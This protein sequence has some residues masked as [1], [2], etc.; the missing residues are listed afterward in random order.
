MPVCAAVKRALYAFTPGLG[1]VAAKQAHVNEGKETTASSAVVG[2]CNGLLVRNDKLLQGLQRT[3][4]ED[5]KAHLVSNGLDASTAAETAL[6]ANERVT[7]ARYAAWAKESPA[8]HDELREAGGYDL[9]TTCD[10]LATI[11]A[12][13]KDIGEFE[14]ATFCI[15]GTAP[16]S[17]SLF[18]P[19]AFKR[20]RIA[21]ATSKR[22]VVLDQAD[23]LGLC[24]ALGRLDGPNDT[25]ENAFY[26]HIV[27]FIA[28]PSSFLSSNDDVVDL[29]ASAFHF[30]LCPADPSLT[31]ARSRLLRLVQWRFHSFSNVQ[32]RRQRKKDACEHCRF[33]REPLE[34][35]SFRSGKPFHCR[36][37]QVVL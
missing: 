30:A 7:S 3:E 15:E 14:G 26:T 8:L 18:Q 23:P 5:L 13:L 2:H 34:V 28:S 12:A 35:C 1:V 27:E 6:K 33:D 19:D 10:T 22:Q 9:Q 21:A 36:E 24:P 32:A 17:S 29:G 25:S 20:A 37:G 31:E 11:D 16:T 4:Y